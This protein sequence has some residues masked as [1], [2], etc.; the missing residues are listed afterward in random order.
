MKTSAYY[1]L[2]ALCFLFTLSLDAQRIN[3]KGSSV[4]EVFQLDQFHTIKLNIPA[5]VKLLQGNTQKVVVS[6]QKNILDLINKEV[7]NEAW[8]IEFDAK[9]VYNYDQVEIEITLPDL[10][11]VSLS[12]SGKIVTMDKFQT[13]DDFKVSISGSGKADLHIEA[14]TIDC[15]IAGS[16]RVLLT[17]ATN[18]LDI[19][20][21]G[22]GDL[23]A[24][25]LTSKHCSISTAGSGDVRVQVSE[26]LNASLVG[27]GDVTYVGSPKV[28]VSMAGSGKVRPRD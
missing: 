18:E 11:G 6:G 22:S 13:N 8:K 3:G 10:A 23:E 5:K 7:K 1:S 19:N 17:G 24:Y 20:T 9:K 28:K 21:T 2:F 16:G 12:G 14:A 26:S 15:S 27:S 25:E 4:T